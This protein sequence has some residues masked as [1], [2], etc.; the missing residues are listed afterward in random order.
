MKKF[1]HE[2]D[3]DLEEYSSF[4]E[5]EAEEDNIGVY[6]ERPKRS[7][8][9][10]KRRKSFNIKEKLSKCIDFFRGFIERIKNDKKA[11]LITVVVSVL[12][13]LLI[14]SLIF[15]GGENN[16]ESKKVE[17][18]TKKTITETTTAV[19][20]GTLTPE[21][22]DSKIQTLITSYYNYAYIKS[23]MTELSK[24]IDSMDGI[25]AE[26]FSV[27]HKYIEKCDNIVCY[28]V[29]SDKKNYSIL[30]VTASYKLFNIATPIPSIDV[31]VL[32]EDKDG[33]YLIHNITKGEELDY[34]MSGQYNKEEV[35]YLFSSVQEQLNIA[36][37]SDADLK[38]IYEILLNK[39]G[40]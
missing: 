8:G 5:I 22:A 30:Y 9:Y 10:K 26:S 14:F 20:A 29:D 1:S 15:G 4:K 25:T 3:N 40:Q 35:N 37:Q 2:Q 23:D 7:Y 38:K 17:K 27:W 19:A 31:F 34:Y 28:K 39:T 32:V 33:N 12:F 21:A 24:V 6:K 13:L 18:T 16:T 11:L 36:L